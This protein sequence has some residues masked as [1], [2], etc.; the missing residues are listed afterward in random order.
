MTKS[1]FP[2]R[3]VNGAVVRREG[4]IL[5]SGDL[6]G[7]RPWETGAAPVRETAPEEPGEK[8]AEAIVIEENE[9]ESVKLSKIAGWPHFDEGRNVNREGSHADSRTHM[10]RR[11]KPDRAE[12]RRGTRRVQSLMVASE[13]AD[14]SLVPESCFGADDLYEPPTTDPYGGWC[15][16][17]GLTT[18][19][20]PIRRC[21]HWLRTRRKESVEWRISLAKV[22]DDEMALLQALKAFD[23]EA[24]RRQFGRVHLLAVEEKQSLH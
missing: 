24:E 1:R 13:M 4:L 22:S 16:S 8:S 7:R 2:P 18:P 19:G 17:R 11:L 6:A 21:G 9:P 20:D 12:S 5:T 15:G 3:T 23:D 10:L 14:R